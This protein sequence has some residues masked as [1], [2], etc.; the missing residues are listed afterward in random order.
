[1][2]KKLLIIIVIVIIIILVTGFY[3]FKQKKDI[4]L[5]QLNTD[6]IQAPIK[7]E[8]QK[9]PYIG[10][11]FTILPPEGWIRTQLPGTLVSY[12][13]PK[14][15]QPAGSA[16][17][18]INFH[19]YLAVSF[20]NSG[21]KTLDEITELVKTQIQAVAPEIVLES[22]TDGKIDGEPAKFI[23]ANLT[24]QNV[25][26]KVMMAVALKGDK[27]FTIS[28]NTTA[29]KWPEYRDI[30]YNAAKSFRFKY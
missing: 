27:Y 30:F 25:D 20:D 24:M 9:N 22:T 15:K 29:E 28:N 13:D 7:T 14:E 3:F 5:S 19:S 2:K 23:E 26:F 18:K 11:D 8:D 1:M 4:N 17:E 10:D 16:A 12:Q 6:N 21:G